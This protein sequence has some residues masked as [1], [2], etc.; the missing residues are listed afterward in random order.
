VI[1][2]LLLLDDN[3]HPAQ[4]LCGGETGSILPSEADFHPLRARGE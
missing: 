4:Q 1:V 2:H 3:V